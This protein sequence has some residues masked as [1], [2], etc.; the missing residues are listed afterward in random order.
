M[1]SAKASTGQNAKPKDDVPTSFSR[2][3]W[4]ASKVIGKSKKMMWVPKGSTPIKAE[5]I[6]QTSTARTTLKS[7]PHMTS[8]VL[9]SKHTN[10]KADL[11]VN[12]VTVDNCEVRRLQVGIR[13]IGDHIINSHH[14]ACQCMDKGIRIQVCFLICHGPGIVL[15]CS[16]MSLYIILGLFQSHIPLIDLHGRIKIDYCIEVEYK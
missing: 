11:G 4:H 10:K 3:T 1:V 16:M 12:R 15:G 6:T 9:L 13:I 2:I 5:L 14:S 7:E 8:K